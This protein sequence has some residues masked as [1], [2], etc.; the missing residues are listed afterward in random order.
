M[1]IVYRKNVKKSTTNSY[2]G[3]SII[4]EEPTYC[5]EVYNWNGTV[6]KKIFS[7]DSISNLME[8]ND[9]YYV[10]LKKT[11]KE[12]EICINSY[13][14]Q[15]QYT[16][17][18]SS[19]IYRMSDESFESIFSARLESEYGYRS[20]YIDNEY[21]YQ[22]TFE[23]KAYSVPMFLNDDGSYDEEQYTV[24]YLAGDG[25]EKYTTVIND[26]VKVI[27]SLNKN[28]VAED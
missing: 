5:L 11:D 26:T 19:K 25:S 13:D 8:D 16:Y 7:T 20:Y 23:D 28:Y 10:M 2:S 24:I 12:V 27:E 21:T 14:Y 3:E 17:T 4:V 18:A 1:L 6:A 22:S 15:S 9:T